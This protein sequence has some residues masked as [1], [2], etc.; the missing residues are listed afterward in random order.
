MP[1]WPSGRA[2]A[3]FPMHYSILCLIVAWTCVRAVILCRSRA[4]GAVLA[5]LAGTED[6]I[7]RA[8]YALSTLGDGAD[9]DDVQFERDALAAQLEHLNLLVSVHDA[10]RM[11]SLIAPL[12]WPALDRVVDA[13]TG[14]WAASPPPHLGTLYYDSDGLAPI[15]AAAWIT[16][17]TLCETLMADARAR[18]TALLPTMYALLAER[19]FF[20]AR[21]QCADITHRLVLDPNTNTLVCQ[22]PVDKIC[23]TSGLRHTVLLAIVAGLYAVLA[24]IAIIVLLYAAITQLD[25][26]HAATLDMRRR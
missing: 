20:D 19:T 25:R 9:A 7:V 17:A 14:R 5:H 26:R 23:G 21:P 18:R 11:P 15:H 1:R 8:Q 4:E 16:N 12:L 6:N 2:Y 10:Q 22:C 3:A 13:G 24:L